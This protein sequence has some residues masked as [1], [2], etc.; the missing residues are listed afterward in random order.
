MATGALLPLLEL[1]QVGKGVE[2]RT[3][4]K[5]SEFECCQRDIGHCP[6][7]SDASLPAYLGCW[8]YRAA[9]LSARWLVFHTRN[10]ST[11]VAELPTEKVDGLVNFIVALGLDFGPDDYEEHK[12]AI[13]EAV[14]KRHHKRRHPRCRAAA[15]VLLSPELA[16]GALSD[17]AD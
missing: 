11:D 4:E 13:R 10:G 16:S 8:S 5:I 12:A 1:P 6:E 2:V 14:D 17:E 9:F 15:R 7:Y 3:M